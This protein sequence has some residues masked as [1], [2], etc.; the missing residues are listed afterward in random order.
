MPYKDP[1]KKA[2]YH[3]EYSRKWFLK[4]K[5]RVLAYRRDWNKRN[6]QSLYVMEYVKRSP[7]HRKKFLARSKVYYA[8]K[9]GKLNKGICVFLE[10]QTLGEAHH[11]DYDQPLKVTW[12]CRK[13]HSQ[14]H[15]E[16]KK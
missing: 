15:F 1:I 11:D 9:T 3:K 7:L 6:N 4:N 2:L 12:L 14:H 8:L 5:E 10:C 13:H 16:N